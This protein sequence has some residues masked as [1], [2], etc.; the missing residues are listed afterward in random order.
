M[1]QSDEDIRYY[2][3]IAYKI[4]WIVRVVLA[5]LLGIRMCPECPH[6]NKGK[7]PCQDAFGSNAEPQGGIFGRVDSLFGGV[8]CQR[9]GALHLHFSATVQRAHRHKTLHE[10]AVLIKSKLLSVDALKLYHGYVCRE[11]YPDLAKQQTEADRLEQ[12]WHTRYREDTQLG[13]IPAFLYAD[14]SPHLLSPGL[15]LRAEHVL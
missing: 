2:E 8:E 13:R 4:P 7:S 6:C 5:R 15:R 1:S 3:S 9:T 12:Q 14:S 10:I 11:T